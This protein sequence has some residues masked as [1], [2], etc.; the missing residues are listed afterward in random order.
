MPNTAT[1]TVIPSIV[2]TLGSVPDFSLPVSDQ[3]P[4]HPIPEAANSAIQEDYSRLL[5]SYGAAYKTKPP[6]LEVR[7]PI[8]NQ[9]WIL[10][11]SVIPAQYESLLN[12]ILPELLSFKVAFKIVQ[13]N[14][15][16]KDCNNGIYGNQKVGKAITVYIEDGL[17]VPGLLTVLVAKT[18]NYTGPNISTDYRICHNL[19]YR[20]GSFQ[21]IIMTDSYGNRER[22]MY[23]NAGNLIKDVYNTPPILPGWVKNPFTPYQQSPAATHDA[24][25]F[26]S[27]Y[28]PVRLLKSDKKGDV[29]K[30]LYHKYALL[31]IGCIIKQGR[32]GLFADDGR[33]DMR[34]RILWQY[35]VMQKLEN[36]LNVPHMIDLLEDKEQ[37]FLVMSLINGEPLAKKAFAIINNRPWWL[38]PSKE[39]KEIIGYLL[40]TVK[41]I[42]VLHNSGYL[43]RDI[44][45]TNFLVTP[46]G[47]IFLVDLELAYHYQKKEPLLPFQQGTPGYMSPR[48]RNY[49]SPSLADDY[50]AIGALLLNCLT[51]IEP[52]FL[53]QE[54]NRDWL[55][56]LFFFFHDPALVNF[57][58]L[59]LHDNQEARPDT[60][61]VILFLQSYQSSLTGG[62]KMEQ[63]AKAHATQKEIP[64]TKTTRQSK[65]HPEAIKALIKKYLHSLSGS[66]LAHEGLWFSYLNNPYDTA[67]YPL[68]NKAFYGA[69]NRGIG[70]PL[71]FLAEAK[72]VGFDTSSAAANSKTAWEFLDKNILNQNSP[73]A[74]G[75][76]FGSSG[77]AVLLAKAIQSGMLPADEYYRSAIHQCLDKASALLDVVH[78][79]AGEGLAILHCAGFLPK[80]I[81]ITLLENRVLETQEK[82][83]SW[84]MTG[85]DNQPE[86]I[87]GF[88]YGIAGIVYFLLEYSHRSESAD[89]IRTGSAEQSF[90]AIQTSAARHAAERG[91]A[92]LMKRAIRRKNHYEWKN[93]DR[94]Q[95]TGKWW[96]HGGPGIAL[97]FLKAFEITGKDQYHHFAQQALY[98]HPKELSTYQISL[99]HGAAGLGEIYLEA[100]RVT[101]EE[102]WQERASRITDLLCALQ[103]QKNTGEVYWNVEQR[104]FPTADLMIGS[105]GIAHF[106][107]RWLYPE[108]IGF[109]LLPDPEIHPDNDSID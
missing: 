54:E 35:Q 4:G 99:C 31:P 90:A 72:K 63:A 84:K 93:S 81:K 56:Q 83:G 85:E 38:L 40:Q 53:V 73:V 79:I 107:L 43:H 95:Q 20:Y 70:G 105:S 24:T 15:F 9:G 1:H 16:L 88:G 23:D 94:S 89:I 45:G 55:F 8:Q 74:P 67:I 109:P 57:I 50:Y 92:Y 3:L 28:R 76:H 36:T 11:L 2:T 5:E 30:G 33:T 6:F 58:G 51:G 10:H 21:P 100:F 106:L 52:S 66:L 96:C 26:L 13:N 103:K 91:L 62:R 47:K 27:K 82:D 97:T 22:L 17:D 87:A 12:V 59:C 29:Y 98:I 25:L 108:Q 44:T 41:Q 18:N 65:T 64:V 39:Q 60:N 61:R 42:Q 68:N 7:E 19:Y 37:N 71:Y 34:D 75:L 46:A 48:Q 78:G 32:M 69:V 101:R 49:Q 104:E 102:Q 77:I 86:K 80:E 14:K